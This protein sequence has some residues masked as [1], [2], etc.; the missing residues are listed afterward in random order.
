MVLRVGTDC[1]GIEA[2]IQA[3][4]ALKIPFKHVFSCE[5]DKYCI[6][7]I[8]ANYE[9]EIIYKDITKRNV[10]NIPDIDLYVCGFP[11]QTFSMAGNRKGTKDKRGKIFNYCLEVIEKK[12]PSYFILENVK[13]L[14]SIDKGKTFENIIESLEEISYYDIYWKVLN[15][16]DYG[17][18]QNR[19][20]VFIIG[21]AKELNI[22]FEFPKNKLCKE[23]SSYVDE[24]DNPEIK[25]I[26]E[27]VLY[28]KNNIPKDSIFIDLAFKNF[29]YPNSNKYSPCI[30]RNG[31]LWCVPMNRYANV[32]ELLAL[33]G[34]PKNFKQVVSKSQLKKQ[35]GNSMSV[36]VLKEILKQILK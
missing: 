7:S 4:K 3:L 13:G 18:P 9:P 1:S 19:E 33:Q 26:P 24:K 21:I 6:E 35:I 36:C 17:I 27:R 32:K 16:K 22:K 14:L 15:T 30:A 25:S 28:M 12:L 11:C 23:L 34:F 29:A 20:R 5:I 8:K 10:S 2:P 31:S